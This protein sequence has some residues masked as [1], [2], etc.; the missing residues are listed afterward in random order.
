MSTLEELREGFLDRTATP[1]KD[2]WADVPAQLRA[3]ILGDYFTGGS[4][5]NFDDAK[6]IASGRFKCPGHDDHNP[7]LTVSV[8]HEGRVGIFCHTGCEREAVRAAIGR[9]WSAFFPPH[10]Q[11]SKWSSVKA[12]AEKEYDGSEETVASREAVLDQHPDLIVELEAHHFT[13]DIRRSYR[14]GAVEFKGE[15]WISV[16]MRRPFHDDFCGTTFVMPWSRR[17]QRAKPHKRI[18][19]GGQKGFFGL[20]DDVGGGLVIL[21]EGAPAAAALEDVL[22]V[23]ALG[24]PGAGFI[25]DASSWW[26]TADRRTYFRNLSLTEGTEYAIWADCDPV[27]RRAALKVARDLQ[28]DHR[29]TVRLLDVDRNREDGYDAADVLLEDPEGGTGRLLDLLATTDPLE[30][31]KRGPKSEDREKAKAA[32]TALLVAA[33]GQTL[34]VKFLD[35][36]VGRQ[37]PKVSPKTLQRIRAE[38]CETPTKSKVRNGGWAVKLKGNPAT[39]TAHLHVEMCPLVHFTFPPAS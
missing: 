3:P 23:P 31:V 26:A 19:S 28:R 11:T 8:D 37:F 12:T 2:V 18:E 1:V 21:A 38:I 33:D 27:G 34:P 15:I 20:R 29:P 7:S 14:V 36:E 32:M 24:Y 39:S 13:E 25:N 16:P 9:P 22:G 6:C 10:L 30:P 5:A 4:P 35:A 17:P